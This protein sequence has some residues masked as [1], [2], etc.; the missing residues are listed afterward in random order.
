MEKFLPAADY[1]GRVKQVCVCASVRLH[2]ESET[3]VC[4]IQS[5]YIGRVK[6]VCVCVYLSKTT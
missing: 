5:D 1:I 4:V 6:Q 2:R 3:D